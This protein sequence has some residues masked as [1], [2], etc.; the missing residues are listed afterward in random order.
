MSRMAKAT[1]SRRQRRQ[2]DDEFKA[3]AVALVVEAERVPAASRD[4]DLTETALRRWVKQAEADRTHG[5]T[6][7]TTVEREE[8][9]RLRRENRELRTDREILKKPRPSSRSTGSKVRLNCRGEG[10]LPGAMCRALAVSP[11]GF[12]AWCRR[13]ESARAKGDRELRVFIRAS[14]ERHKHRYGSPRIL[15]DLVEAGFRVVLFA[16]LAV[17]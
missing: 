15:K 9:A 14:F 10:L 8:L 3:Q 12:H 5:S 2:F 7:L 17:A 6:G 16:H 11:S 4:L 1:K 13:P